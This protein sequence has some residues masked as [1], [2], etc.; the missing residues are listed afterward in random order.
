MFVC[1]DCGRYF[2]VPKKYVEKHGLD[3]PPYE[4]LS[5]CPYCYGDYEEYREDEE[6]G[7]YDEC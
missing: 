5:G 3:C 7:E 4:T 1:L 2:D 6:E